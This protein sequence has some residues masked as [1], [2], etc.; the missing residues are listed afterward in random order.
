MRVV[1][2]RVGG[3]TWL[4]VEAREPEGEGEGFDHVLNPDEILES[5]RAK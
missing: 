5:G 1:C 3:A 2:S 4:D